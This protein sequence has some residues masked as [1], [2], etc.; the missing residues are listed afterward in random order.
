ML[1]AKG[2]DSSMLRSFIQES[3]LTFAGATRGNFLI[4]KDH[5]FKWLKKFLV[6]STILTAIILA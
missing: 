3:I 2:I 4:M 6:S 5:F 1:F